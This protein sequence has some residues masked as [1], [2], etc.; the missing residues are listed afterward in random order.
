MLRDNL[1]PFTWNYRDFGVINF[2]RYVKQQSVTHC[3]ID[4][5]ILLGTGDCNIHSNRWLLEPDSVT[6]DKICELF[7]SP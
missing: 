5:L 1:G 2:R 7:V 3:G 6:R 4:L